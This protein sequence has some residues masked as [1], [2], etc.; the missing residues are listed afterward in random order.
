MTEISKPEVLIVERDREAGRAMVGYLRDQGY[1]AEWAGDAEKAFTLLDSRPFGALV[2]AL[3][4]GRADGL[5]VMAVARGRNPDICV[6]L[7]SDANDI[8]RATE[9]VR[10]G[11]Y[12]Y[13]TRPVNLAKLE[14]VIQRGLAYQQLSLTKTELHRRL[15]ERF[16]LASL[17]GRSRLMAQVYNAVRQTGPLDVPVLIHGEPGSGK[18]LI[19]QALHHNS[20][21]R[22]EPFVSLDC[23]GVPEVVV[24]SELFGYAVG[25][26]MGNSP[27]RQGRFLLADGGTLYLAGVDTLSPMLQERLYETLETSKA[28]R[29]GDGKPVRTNVRLIAGSDQRLEHL[30]TSDAYHR[31]LA[32]RLAQVVIEAPALRKRKDD[33]PLLAL[34]ILRDTAVHSGKNPGGFDRHAL[35][36]L[37]RYDWPG[38]IRELENV[39]EEM[40]ATAPNQATLREADVPARIRAAATPETGQMCLRVGMTMDE[41]EQTAIEETLRVC[42]NDR[43]ACARMLGIGLR[44]LYRKLRQYREER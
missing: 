3:Q 4:L 19:A 30:S 9:G 38:N 22:D 42:D 24:R 12:D 14:G 6:V 34:R 8:D 41:I 2:T 10:L 18:R 36:L 25:R 23:R 11:A 7:L 39:V 5:H 32:A 20:P 29:P 43:E 44:T 31:G 13:Q 16:G 26:N 21:R 27:L 33:I 17:A 40:I 37:Q 35:D 1:N 28:P 15:D